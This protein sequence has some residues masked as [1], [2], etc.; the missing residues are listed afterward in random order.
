M[1]STY[2]GA[3]LASDAKQATK[4]EARSCATLRFNGTGSR[5]V[6]WFEDA[7]LVRRCAPFS[8]S[9]H[10]E[11]PGDFFEDAHPFRRCAPKSAHLRRSLQMAGR[12]DVA[13]IG[14]TGYCE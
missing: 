5:A 1:K 6:P 3:A 2:E 7:H 11:N 14:P 13:R 9:A 4:A 12:Q 8:K 10:L